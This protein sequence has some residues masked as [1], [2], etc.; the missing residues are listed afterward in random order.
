[1]RSSC[2]FRRASTTHVGIEVSSGFRKGFS[3]EDWFLTKSSDIRASCQ[4]EVPATEFECQ[5][6]EL[7]W[8]CVCW[9]G[10][11]VREST[12]WTPSTFRGSSWNRIREPADQQYALNK[13]RVLL[14]RARKG[15]VIWVPPQGPGDKTRTPPSFDQTAE[16]FRACGLREL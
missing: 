11:L 3:Y 2:Q 14:T 1:M 7:D 5:G 16:Y 4:M 13:Y 15:M 6:L 8:T 10:D 12:Q 9:G